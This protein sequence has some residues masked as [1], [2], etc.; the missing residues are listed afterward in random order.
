M[1]IKSSGGGLSIP[2]MMEPPQSSGSATGN[3]RNKVALKPGHSLMDWVRLG[4]SGVDLSG[5]GGV[6]QNVTI[7]QLAA[8]NKRNDAW[9]AIRGKVYNV[10]KYMDF[11]PGGDDELMRGVGKDAT[12]LFNQ[13]HAWVNYESLLHKCYVGRLVYSDSNSGPPII[14]KAN[15]LIGKLFIKKDKC[16]TMDWYQ[17]MSSINLQFFT[18]GGIPQ[19]RVSL[20]KELT[21]SIR[22]GGMSH[23]TRIVLEDS[24]S[25][26]C[27]VRTNYDSGKVEV[28]L[29]KSQPGIWRSLGQQQHNDSTDKQDTMFQPMEIVYISQVTH[30]TKLVFLR[31]KKCVLDSFPIGSSVQV[32]AN[33]EGEEVVRSYTPVVPALHTDLIASEWRDYLCLMV[34]EYAKGAMSRHICSKTVKENLTVGHPVGS[35]SSLP[36]NTHLILLAAGTGFT[37]MVQIIQWGL[38]RKKLVSMSLVFFN[39]SE[40]DIIWKD[41]LDRLANS[42]SRFT[43]TYVLSAPSDEWSG[44]SGRLSLDLLRELQLANEKKLDNF[45]FVCGPLAFNQLAQKLLGEINYTDDQFYIFQG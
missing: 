37:P 44:K 38:G 32:Q 22:V 12:E 39:V 21:V 7:S 9:L 8:H 13:V 3:P 25:W 14:N 27:K 35:L 42:D 4:N 40:R 29:N 6:P 31:H 19:T 36:C 5:V 2:K 17:Q 43:V 24:V 26:P 10:T 11:H 34:K 33:L 18:R 28:L 23:V 16:V 45:V 30:N 20:D 15:N 1:S 41:Q